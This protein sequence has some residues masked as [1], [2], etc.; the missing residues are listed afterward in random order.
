MTT[1]TDAGAVDSWD[2]G[3][4]RAALE[5]AMELERLLAEPAFQVG[6]YTG[7]WDEAVLLEIRALS[8]TLAELASFHPL[9]APATATRL[10][11]VMSAWE[12]FLLTVQHL[13]A[14]GF[15]PGPLRTPG[16][17]AESPLELLR[18]CHAQLRELGTATGGSAAAS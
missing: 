15:E 9:V 1:S 11:A 17:L 18:A 6:C 5:L 8:Y 12:A 10:D 14:V 4:R 16:H 3:V 13:L 2:A 7:T